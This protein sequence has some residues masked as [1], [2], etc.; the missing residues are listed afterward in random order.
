M[1][2][3]KGPKMYWTE[4]ILCHTMHLILVIS[5]IMD[6]NE[7]LAQDFGV[8][9]IHALDGHSRMVLGFITIPKK[10]SVLIYQFFFSGKYAFCISRYTESSHTK[11]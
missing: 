9:H 10:N 5:C 4:Q 11:L 7:K 8:T 2:T 1:L 6:Q 3:E